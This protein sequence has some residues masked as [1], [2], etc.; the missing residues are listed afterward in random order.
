MARNVEKS[1]NVLN[2]L[3]NAKAA[4]LRTGGGPP[5]PAR[6]PFLASECSDLADADRWRAQ[7]VREIGSKVMEIQNAGLGEHRSGAGAG[8]S[9]LVRHC[10]AAGA[11]AAELAA[12]AWSSIRAAP[13]PAAGSAT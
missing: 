13:S 4:E 2:R 6:R 7:V 8:C 5:K 9:H 11:A 10:P 3:L 1:Q 12:R